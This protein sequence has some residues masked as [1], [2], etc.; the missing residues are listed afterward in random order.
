MR[1]APLDGVPLARQEERWTYSRGPGHPDRDFPVTVDIGK[2]FDVLGLKGFDL[3]EIRAYARALAESAKRLY[4]H[5]AGIRR[6]DNCPAC[7]AGTSQAG[8]ALRV[9]DVS[10]RRCGECGHVFV[11][12]QPSPET[13]AEVFAGSDEHSAV[14]IDPKTAERRIAEIVTPKIDWLC[15]V[16]QRRYRTQPRHCVD[17]GAGGGH[18]VAAMRRRGVR[19]EGYELSAASRRFA[20]SA[21]G[22]ALHERDFLADRP[23]PVDLVTFWGVLEYTPEPRRFLEAARRRLRPEGGML[24]VEVPRFN[25]LGTVAQAVDSAVVARHMDPTSHVN[26]FSDSSLATAL[27]ETGFAPVA[28]WYFGMD[29]YEFFVQ[30]ALRLSDS[31]MIDRAA[32][33]LNGLQQSCDFGRQCDDIILTAVPVP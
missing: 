12:E 29:A 2:R 7:D 5:K 18:F 31:R 17:V 6:I 25:A 22:I 28:A 26:C 1:T 23:A 20:E 30:A 3:D 27:V 21:F 24:V 19:A 10:Y 15:E 32:D 16:F 9:F 8:E 33:M 11:G 4:G 14:Y 13:L